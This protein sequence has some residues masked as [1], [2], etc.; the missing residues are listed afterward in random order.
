MNPWDIV[1]TILVWAFALMALLGGLIL[2][3]GVGVGIVKGVRRWFT[4][5]PDL[6]QYLSEATSMANNMYKDEIIMKQEVIQAF[7]DGARWGWGYH[8][9]TPVKKS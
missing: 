4:P 9:R 2:V 8:R 6:Q 7:R 5:T 3:F 1:W